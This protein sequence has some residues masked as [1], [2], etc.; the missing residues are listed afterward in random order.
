MEPL[1]SAGP[2]PSGVKLGRRDADEALRLRAV[3]TPLGVIPIEV[4][5]AGG[6]TYLWEVQSAFD[7]VAQGAA[8]TGA[9]GDTVQVTVASA[10]RAPGAGRHELR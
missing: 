6:Q 1:T 2:L 8:V 9:V 7:I 5:G 4:N 10:T 3:G